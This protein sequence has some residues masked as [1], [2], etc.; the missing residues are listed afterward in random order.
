MLLHDFDVRDSAARQ[1]LLLLEIEYHWLRRR[2]ALSL[3]TLTQWDRVICELRACCTQ[4]WY[5]E[6][7]GI[8]GRR[9][10]ISK[11]A[12]IRIPQRESNRIG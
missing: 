11:H 5:L 6:T 3:A 2:C 8:C 7:T 4:V 12:N 1:R 10:S 9:N